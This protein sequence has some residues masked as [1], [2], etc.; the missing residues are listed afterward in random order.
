MFQSHFYC[1]FPALSSPRGLIEL[2]RSEVMAP[3]DGAEHPTRVEQES[4]LTKD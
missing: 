4:A 2:T 1:N 3:I